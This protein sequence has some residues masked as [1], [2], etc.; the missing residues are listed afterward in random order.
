[1]E[2]NTGHLMKERFEK[3]FELRTEKLRLEARLITLESDYQNTERTIKTTDASIQKLES[4]IP[5]LLAEQSARFDKSFKLRTQK[6][7]LK[8]KITELEHEFVAVNDS[9]NST[10]GSISEVETITAA[11]LIEQPG[12]VRGRG[13]P[14]KSDGR[15]EGIQDA[16]ASNSGKDLQADKLSRPL[17]DGKQ[18]N[19]RPSMYTCTDASAFPRITDD[20]QNKS[21]RGGDTVMLSKYHPT[22]V[23]LDGRWSLIWCPDC[24][25]NSVL[26]GSF[27]MGFAGLHVHMRR[28]NCKRKDHGRVTTEVVTRRCGRYLL[29]EL[30]LEGLRSGKI[31]IKMRQGGQEHEYVPYLRAEYHC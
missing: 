4:S 14:R 1:M 17:R 5:V 26:N 13:R 3:S 2:T 22:V 16:S 21:S 20:D 27:F 31:Q 7:V 12:V 6:A 9:I 11:D 15:L 19:A 8:K 30:E 10:K 18:W 28:S 29:T 24:G 25:D 23:K